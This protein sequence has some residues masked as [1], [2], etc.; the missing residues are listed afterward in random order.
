[1]DSRN[2]AE[3]AAR[4][5]AVI[6]ASPARRAWRIYRRG[7]RVRAA[8]TTARAG[9]EHFPVPAIA[10]RHRRSDALLRMLDVVLAVL[11]LLV[12]GPLMVF[13]AVAVAVSSRGPI[14]FRQTRYGLGGRPFTILKFRTMRCQENGGHV[15]QARRD[16]PR[17]TRVGR[18]LRQLSLD[19]LP[20]LINVVAG[21]MSLVGPRPHALAHDWAFSRAVPAYGYRFGVRPGITGLAQIHGM[22]GEVSSSTQIRN[23]VLYDVLYVRRR[24]VLLYCRVLLATIALVCFQDEAY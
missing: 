18:L 19:E 12:L 5:N 2:L 3:G 20:Q 13:I 23:R 1:M 9:A 16:D 17:V 7:L 4:Y 15:Q 11:A 21:A 14:L 10:L 22:R 24:G 8:E 6:L